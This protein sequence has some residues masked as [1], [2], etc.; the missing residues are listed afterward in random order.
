MTRLAYLFAWMTLLAWV[1]IGCFGL[2]LRDEMDESD[3]W[4]AL[5]VECAENK[6]N[7]PEPEP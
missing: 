2:I 3:R 4:E 7:D 1:L 6:G 5:Y